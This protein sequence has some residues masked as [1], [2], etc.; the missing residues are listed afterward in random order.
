MSRRLER[1]RKRRRGKK[2]RGW[3][4]RR[5]VGAILVPRQVPARLHYAATTVYREICRGILLVILT[6]SL[7]LGIAQN[8]VNTILE[9][10]GDH[11]LP[12]S[13]WRSLGTC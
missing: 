4:F 1:E 5:C 2:R 13:P 3:G 12:E 8:L 10:T 11:P 6:A 7:K 9:I